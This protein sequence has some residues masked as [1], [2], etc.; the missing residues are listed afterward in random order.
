[1][2]NTKKNE[3]QDLQGMINDLLA[4]ALQSYKG[5]KEMDALRY[6]V[7]TIRDLMEE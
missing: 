5:R 2:A 3:E 6:Q 1:M 7:E 4:D